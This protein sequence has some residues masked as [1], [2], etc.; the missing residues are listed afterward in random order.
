M[1]YVEH[2][3]DYLWKF[4]RNIDDTTKVSQRSWLSPTRVAKHKSQETQG[5]KA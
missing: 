3:Y 1:L 4:Y 2:Y 5:R